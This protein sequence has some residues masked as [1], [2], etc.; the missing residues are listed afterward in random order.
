MHRFIF[1]SLD[2][3]KDVDGLLA[4]ADL[5]LVTAAGQVTVGLITS[6]LVSD[7]GAAPALI[8]SLDACKRERRE[9]AGILALA[10]RQRGV[11]TLLAHARLEKRLQLGVIEV[12]AQ[13]SPRCRRRAQGGLGGGR[14][15]CWR[16]CCGCLG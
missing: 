5:V 6:V 2:G 11:T 1:V 8:A 7:E 14:G 13:S 12:A 15:A 10:D 9:V 4:A 3:L 16:G